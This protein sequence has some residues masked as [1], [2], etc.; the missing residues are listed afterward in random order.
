MF[1]ASAFCELF[2]TTKER[3]NKNGSSSNHVLQSSA[4]YRR[5]KIP[6]KLV[7]WEKKLYAY[8]SVYLMSSFLPERL[9][10]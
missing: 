5:V 6:I 7:L 9:L 10:A 1:P 8:I 2:S 4:S 3:A